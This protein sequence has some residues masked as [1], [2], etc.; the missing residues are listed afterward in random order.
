MAEGDI[1]LATTPHRPGVDL[2]ISGG[3]DILD[4]G[5]FGG[6]THNKEGGGRLTPS[7]KNNVV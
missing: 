1:T 6:A 4:V 2:E 5:G 3:G 7:H